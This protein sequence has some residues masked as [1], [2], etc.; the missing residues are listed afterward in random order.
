M[1]AYHFDQIRHVHLEISSMCNAAC[2]FCPR[3]LQGF[4]YNEGYIEKNM[5][6]KEAK[7]IFVP[8]FINQLDSILVN[9]NFGD[10]VM[11]P[12]S[13][14]ILEYFREVNTNVKIIISTN[15]SARN[16]NFWTRLANISAE[17]YFCLDGLDD[18]HHLHRRNTL[19][20]TVIQNART[21]ISAGGRA[22][23]KMLTFDHNRHQ[24]DACKQMS[25]QL[26]FADFVAM[27]GN[28]QGAV[29]D[30]DGNYAYSI[31]QSHAA[32]IPLADLIAQKLKPKTVNLDAINDPINQ[33][34][35]EVMHDRSIY[36]ASTGEVYPCCHLGFQ[37]QTYGTGFFR[38]AN[39]QVSALMSNNNAL[40]HSIE[41]CIKWF[42]KVVD[43]W[44][45]KDFDQGRLVHCNRQCGQQN[46]IQLHTT[47]S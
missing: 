31:N 12:Q 3:N 1:A 13:P 9:G 23:W 33:I 4:P 30:K 29:Y 17:I 15:G 44:Q 10:I 46:A 11:N 26:G 34:N 2:P 8:K 22:V 14:D 7:Q 5:T 21:F 42:G 16:F 43:S 32:V 45:K 25:Q 28:G 38:A 6:L 40:E 37:P 36:V 41:D 47:I 19:W 24:I 18:T 39:Q 35:C 20:S 27:K